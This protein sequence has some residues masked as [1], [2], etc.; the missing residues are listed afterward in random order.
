MNVN[1]NVNILFLRGKQWQIVNWSRRLSRVR[2]SRRSGNESV[3]EGTEEGKETEEGF[4]FWIRSRRVQITRKHHSSAIMCGYR[5]LCLLSY[6]CCGVAAEYAS[7]C[8]QEIC[9]QQ[10][11]VV[12]VK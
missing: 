12:K 9:Q 7:E 4:R 8:V 5:L 11:W 3:S 1:V 10:Q 2:G 6:F